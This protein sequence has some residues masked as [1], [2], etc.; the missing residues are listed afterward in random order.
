MD[1]R[2]EEATESV[3]GP[4]SGV[5]MFP[6]GL[7]SFAEGLLILAGEVDDTPEFECSNPSKPTLF[8][9]SDFRVY[10]EGIIVTFFCT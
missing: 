8:A 5:L 2:F 4:S 7:L 6:D 1:S 9:P 10:L 3:D